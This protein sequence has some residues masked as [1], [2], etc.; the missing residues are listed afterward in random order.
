MQ[1]TDE[2]HAPEPELTDEELLAEVK[3]ARDERRW[4]EMRELWQ[5]LTARVFMYFR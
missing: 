2:C 3:R 1:P 4:R 5:M